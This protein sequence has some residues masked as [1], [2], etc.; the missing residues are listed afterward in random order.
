[1]ICEIT[2]PILDIS[3]NQTILYAILPDKSRD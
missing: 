3:Y 1:M 2:L